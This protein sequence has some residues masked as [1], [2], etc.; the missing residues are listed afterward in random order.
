MKMRGMGVLLAAG[1][2]ACSEAEEGPLDSGRPADAGGNQDSG[3]NPDGGSPGDVGGPG[4]DGGPPSDGGALDDTPLTARPSRNEYSCAVTRGR[5]DHSPRLWAYGGHHLILDQA[6]V[7]NLI[8]IESTPTQ[9]FEPAPSSFVVSTLAADGTFGANHPLVSTDP[10]E[11]L[12]P[13]AAI[14]G[15]GLAVVYVEG[16]HVRFVASNGAGQVVVPAK[17]LPGITADFQTRAHLVRAG[18]GYVVVYHQPGPGSTE[19]YFLALDADGTPTGAARKI[20]TTAESYDPFLNLQPVSDGFGLVFRDRVADR[21]QVFFTK[22]SPTGEVVGAK[23]RLSGDDEAGL[24][25]GFDGAGIALLPHG[26]GYLAAWVEGRPGDFSSGAS[27]IVKVA[28]LDAAGAVRGVAV[29]AR[30]HEVDIDEVEPRLT[31]FG[32]AVALTWARGTHIYICGGCTPDHRI[33]LL[34][35]DPD[36]LTPLSNV[37]TLEA[38]PGGRGGGMLK[39]EVVVQGDQLLVV[40]DLTFHVTATPGSATFTCQ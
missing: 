31:P 29:P 25:A 4:P 18:S 3:A 9:P 2:L 24:S 40:Y 16:T 33:D 5:T 1:L 38:P 19:G 6:G 17:D 28:R 27:T 23:V 21:F 10:G 32:D 22:L 26:D 20:T 14:R 34:L 7:P 12:G 37:S 35:L 8:R 11:I 39:R 15:D 13:T 36:D 30:D